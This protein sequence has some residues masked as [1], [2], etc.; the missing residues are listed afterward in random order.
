MQCQ[1]LEV[2]PSVEITV[3]KSPPPSPAPS[4]APPPFGLD[5]TFDL[6]EFRNQFKT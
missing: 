1:N 3:A 5:L 6:K 2:F 4:P